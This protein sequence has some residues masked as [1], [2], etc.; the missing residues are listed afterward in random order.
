MDAISV[1]SLVRREVAG[2]DVWMTSGDLAEILP[3]IWS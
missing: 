3:L 2:W 1:P